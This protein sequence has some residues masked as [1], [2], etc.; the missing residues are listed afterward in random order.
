MAVSALIGRSLGRYWG[1]GEALAVAGA[2][3]LAW[4]SALLLDPGFELSFISVLAFFSVLGL[5]RNKKSDTYDAKKTKSVLQFCARIGPKIMDLCRSS[6][7]ATAATTPLVLLH[8]NY[9]CLIAV[10]VNIVAVPYTSFIVLPGALLISFLAAPAP[11][12]AAVLARPLGALL[13]FFDRMLEFFSA[14]PCTVESPGPFCSLGITVMCASILLL[15][16]RCFRLGKLAFAGSV[17]IVGMSF[18]VDPPKIPRKAL[19]VDFLDVGDGDASLITFPDGKHWLVD[20]GGTKKE[21]YDMGEQIVV[22][23]LR[24]LGVTQL[25]AL[26][27]TH[28]DEDHVG[29]MPAVINSFE[30]N[31][32]LENG[33][34]AA[35]EANEKYKMLIAAARKRN[36]A[37]HGPNKIPRKREIGGARVTFLHP[38][39]GNGAYDPAL[40]TNDNSL[41]FLITYRQISFLLTGDISREV[42]EVLVRSGAIPSIDV[43]K[44]PHHGSRSSTSDLFLDTASPA[45]AVC[46]LG[47]WNWYGMPHRDVLKRLSAR[48]ISLWRTDR[49]GAIRITTDGR[50][51]EAFSF[52]TNRRF[53]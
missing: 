25:D 52:D 15:L 28:P 11:N 10:P 9:V 8:F 4:D 30:V 7:A 46:S 6:L 14:F 50:A 37:I 17:L 34:G 26:V 19:T 32:L 21:T 39:R 3:L 29:G 2:A 18:V 33:Q 45:I 31:E 41:V 1:T 36:I 20:A 35:D 22:P 53:Q 40:S 42:E 23:S 38:G 24:A 16:A 51:I 48:G 5:R 27:L 13:D 12:I 47:P 49:Q 44:I 43:L